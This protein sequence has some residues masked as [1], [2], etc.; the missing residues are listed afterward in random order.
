M[1]IEQFL[2]EYKRIG[3]ECTRKSYRGHLTHFDLF[4]DERGLTSE[5]VHPVDIEAFAEWVK[6]RFN[7]R[8][9]K[10]GLSDVAV[11][12]HLAAVSSYYRWR[13]CRKKKLRNPV[14]AFKY[15]RKE[16]R[17]NAP[18][19]G[20]EVVMAMGELSDSEL[21][22]LVV[23][24]FRGSGLR[25]TELVS[26]N[27]R[28]VKIDTCSRGKG[29]KH[30]VSV[31]VKGKGGKTRIVPIGAKAASALLKYLHRRG[32]DGEPALILSSRKRRISRRT[33]QRLVHEAAA[34]VGAGHCHPHEL[35][36]RFATDAIEGGLPD[37]QLKKHLGQVSL[38]H[39]YR[40]IHLTEDGVER[41]FEQ[42]M[43]KISQRSTR[44]PQPRPAH[45]PVKS[46]RA[47]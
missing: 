44:T 36:H 4:L 35:R 45:E 34:K 9:D 17:N 46:S 28:D 43:K 27:R 38:E 16:P 32:E 26:L 40:Y 31:K 8:T 20:P 7:P 29:K 24:L 37:K 23:E 11:Q 33:V 15:R 13:R 6:N 19:I 41:G 3:S 21:R 18:L 1:E 39:T 12:S 47:A 5:A 25:L 42:A 30:S 10:P 2:R 22:N 14:S